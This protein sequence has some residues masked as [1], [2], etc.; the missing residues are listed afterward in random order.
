MRAYVR[1]LASGAVLALTTPAALSQE[2]VTEEVRVEATFSSGLE[3][4]RKNPAIDELLKRLELRD[5]LKREA[6]LQEANKSEATKLIGLLKLPVWL[7]F[8]FGS[9]G[10]VDSFFQQ[11]YMRADMNP[12]KESVL[13]RER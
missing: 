1:I 10:K 2:A 11:N 8:G 6:D 13:F 4:Q 7:P 3:L 5:A 12:P 9:D